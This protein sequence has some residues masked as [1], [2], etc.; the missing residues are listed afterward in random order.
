M[1][2]TVEDEEARPKKSAVAQTLFLLT[3]DDPLC[4]PPPAHPGQPAL[5]ALVTTEQVQE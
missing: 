3:S 2:R 5:P 4:P 1:G